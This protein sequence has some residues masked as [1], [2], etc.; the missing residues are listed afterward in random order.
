VRKTGSIEKLFRI[1]KTFP[2]TFKKTLREQS[3]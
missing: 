2:T 1:K 3:C